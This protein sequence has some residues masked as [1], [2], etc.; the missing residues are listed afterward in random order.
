M[1]V[2][3][4]QDDINGDGNTTLE[5]VSLTEEKAQEGFKKVAA[6]YGLSL[7]TAT[8]Y[9]SIEIW[10]AETGDYVCDLKPITE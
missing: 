2:Y 6:A 1:L 10:D 4:V 7:K 8:R 3:V 9:I 5:S